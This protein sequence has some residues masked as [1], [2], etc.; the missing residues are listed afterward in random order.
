MLINRQI[1]PD[2]VVLSTQAKPFPVGLAV[3]VIY[4]LLEDSDFSFSPLLLHCKNRENSG[5]SR[6]IRS[7]QAEN[8]VSANPESVASDSRR[9]TS[10]VV[11]L[12]K[13]S[14]F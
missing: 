10:C 11:L 4:A 2:Q 7:K 5:L 14:H 1:V 13:V 8:L 3:E 12:V 6:A 9:Y